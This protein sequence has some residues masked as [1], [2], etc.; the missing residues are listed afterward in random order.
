VGLE[1]GKKGKVKESE[2]EARWR[3][4]FGPSKNFGVAPL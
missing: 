2:G 4:R 3:E 1:R